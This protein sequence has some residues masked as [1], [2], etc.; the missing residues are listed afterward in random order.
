MKNILKNSETLFKNLLPGNR[1]TQ[2][3]VK[4]LQNFYLEIISQSS[5]ISAEFKGISEWDLTTSE[6]EIKKIINSW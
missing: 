3:E 2:D 6:S 1:L 4:N 5:K